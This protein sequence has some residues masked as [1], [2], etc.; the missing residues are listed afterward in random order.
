MGPAGSTAGVSL[1]QRVRRRVAILRLLPEAGL[2]T[3]AAAAVLHTFGAVT[4]V[5]F[6]VA[7][8]AVQAAAYR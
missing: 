2:G 4:P 6:I 3:L 7:T 8:S 5:G 1:R